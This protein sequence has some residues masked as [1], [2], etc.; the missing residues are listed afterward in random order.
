MPYVRRLPSGKWQ[1]TVRTPNG[2]R[3]TRTDPLKKVVADWGKEEETKIARGMW[4][5]PRGG[6]TTVAE[7]LGTWLN[8]RVV[9]D[10]T[11]RGDQAVIGNHIRP[12]WADWQLHSITPSEVQSWVRR[13]QKDGVGAH[14]VRRSYNTFRTMLGDAVHDGLIP[15]SPCKRIDLPATPPK[16]PA[17]FS[18]D[19]VD[20]IRDE[21]DVRHHSQSVMT[22]LMVNV[23]LR[24][25]EAAA[26]AG[27]ERPDEDGNP[28]DWL[29]G[30]IKVVGALNQRGQWK[31]YPKS[32][33]SRREVPVPRHNLDE[34][35][36]L[37][38][39]RES[40]A[41]VFV[42][43]RGGKKLSGAN[44]RQYVWYPAID[45][46]NA[47][48]AEENKKRSSAN[49]IPLIPRLDPHDCRHT[50]ASWL[51]QAGVPLS[52]IQKLLGH[53]SGATT[54][55]YAHL[56]PDAHHRVEAAWAALPQSR[57]IGVTRQ[58]RT[59][60]AAGPIDAS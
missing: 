4:R 21:L 57:R 56:A 19:Q 39:G 51:A 52:E 53:E 22:E 7:W 26:V 18:R 30:R 24:W 9:E 29:R 59:G 55:R 28:V 48:I 37:L 2:K 36:P 34:M 49:Q 5:D 41:Y 14:A 60:S 3:M 15:E 1:A 45:R 27:G 13:M 17:W 20:R 38:A 32:R 11:R 33:R 44:W 47:R 50:C 35:G 31:S 54:A 46:A 25:G 43:N 16:L 8:A 6:R 12:H 42:T 10:E 40:N 58:R 23:G